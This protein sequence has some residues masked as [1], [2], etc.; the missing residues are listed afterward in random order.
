MA[1]KYPHTNFKAFD[2]RIPEN[3]GS[4]PSNVEFI[5]GNMEVG[6]PSVPFVPNTPEFDYI[7][8]NG[9]ASEVHDW[10]KLDRRIWN[11]LVDG[12]QF[13]SYEMAGRMMAAGPDRSTDTP[14]MRWMQRFVDWFQ[15]IEGIDVMAPEKQG[16]YLRNAGFEITYEKNT[17]QY[18]DAA[19]T[20][21]VIDA[22]IANNFWAK[23]VRLYTASVYNLSATQNARIIDEVLQDLK[24][25]AARKGYYTSQ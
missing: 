7:M 10:Q 25:N 14:A 11:N 22:A 13:E 2:I 1:K 12:G 4:F 8:A 19:R 18:L 3:V 5:R 9:L 21:D 15:R 20:G 16:G 6:G 23:W 24:A 17:R